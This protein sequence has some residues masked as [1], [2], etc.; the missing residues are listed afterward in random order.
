MA[1][2]HGHPTG[3]G[4]LQEVVAEVFHPVDVDPYVWRPVQSLD[5]SPRAVVHAQPRDDLQEE[6]RGCLFVWTLSYKE[7]WC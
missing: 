5:Q 7:D 3:L 4:E 6:G 2:L 1:N